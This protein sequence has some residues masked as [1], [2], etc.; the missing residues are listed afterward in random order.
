EPSEILWSPELRFVA[1][2][3]ARFEK[4]L[5]SLEDGIRA[6]LLANP[7]VNRVEGV[8]FH[9]LDRTGEDYRV[10]LGNGDEVLCEELTFADS[11]RLLKS[12]EG[13]PS[14]LRIRTSAEG[15]KRFSTSDVGRRW[16]PGGALQVT[17]QHRV[18]VGMG[19]QEGFFST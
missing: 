5:W 3:E 19:T 17:F 18:P 11:W 7:Q 14:A 15:A 6:V 2:R 10:V 12:I 9:L 16:A 1:Q 4:D 13:M 8:P